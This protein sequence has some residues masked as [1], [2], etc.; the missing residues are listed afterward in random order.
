MYIKL[1]HVRVKF[2]VF[3]RCK[4]K[5][6]HIKCTWALI[7]GISSTPFVYL[8]RKE[9]PSNSVI[10]HRPE[11]LSRPCLFR[12]FYGLTLMKLKKLVSRNGHD[13]RLI[14]FAPDTSNLAKMGT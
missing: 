8:P 14:F 2:N 3:T 6:V 9:A 5:Q 1:K 4:L 13:L 7:R 10:S 12:M 11:C